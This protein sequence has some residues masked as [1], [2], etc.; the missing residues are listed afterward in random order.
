MNNQLHLPLVP[1]ITGTIIASGVFGLDPVD[2]QFK[3]SVTPRLQCGPIAEQ[4]GIEC[5]HALVCEIVDAIDG[6]HYTD[7]DYP[8]FSDEHSKASYLFTIDLDSTCFIDN[9]GHTWDV[10]N[11]YQ[12]VYLIPNDSEAKRI[13]G[14]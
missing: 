12:E 6:D 10:P 2:V 13:Q 1:E 11:F 4:V 9:T 7:T 3:F 8:T 14:E 5:Y